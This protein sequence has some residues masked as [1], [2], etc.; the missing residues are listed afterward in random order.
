M[1]IYYKQS[2]NAAVALPVLVMEKLECSLARYIETT[3]K[4]VLPDVKIT[5]I[6]CDVARGLVYLH[7]GCSEPVAHRDLSSNNI[8]LTAKIADFGS[9]CVLDR[10]G[11]WNSAAKLTK[12]PGTAIFM[13]LCRD[14]GKSP[15]LYNC[16]GYLF[17]WLCHYSSSHLGMA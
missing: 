15:L 11:G 16:S 7:E 14:M 17:S 5:E 2:Q 9:A 12:S 13:P 8:R 10:P 6:L 4:D 3:H 1:G